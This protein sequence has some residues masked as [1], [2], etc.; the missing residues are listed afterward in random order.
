MRKF[1]WFFNNFGIFFQEFK[2]KLLGLVVS[3]NNPP[4]FHII[5][6]LLEGIKLNSQCV[7]VILDATYRKYNG[8]YISDN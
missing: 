8:S 3:T 5:S 6:Q 1:E 7:L 2:N 4:L